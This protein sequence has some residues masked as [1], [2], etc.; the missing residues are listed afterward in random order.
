MQNATEI[1]LPLL[2]LVFF[3]HL[4]LRLTSQSNHTLAFSTPTFFNFKN[5]NFIATRVRW[6]HRTY[7]YFNKTT[8]ATNAIKALDSLNT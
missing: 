6:L 4:L 2:L 3:V 1:S 5:R 7:Y 8:T